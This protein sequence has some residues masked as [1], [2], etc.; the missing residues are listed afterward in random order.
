MATPLR[1]AIRPGDQSRG[2]ERRWTDIQSELQRL[3][4]P[5]DVPLGGDAVLDARRRLFAF[6][7]HAYHLKDALKAEAGTLGIGKAEVETGIN[8]E[9]TLTL[10]ADLANLD[11]H[12]KLTQSPRSGHIPHIGE[13]R[14][15]QAGSG[16]GGWQL[17]QV[18]EHNGK[19]LDGLTVAKD[20]VA[21]WE[22]RLTGWGLL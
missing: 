14:G 8:A 18:I 13:V 20:A 9:P 2:W 15:S 17:E 11:K 10:L 16:E 4:A 5:P 12:F 3:L 1:T 21:A 7:V 6:F 22:R 19:A